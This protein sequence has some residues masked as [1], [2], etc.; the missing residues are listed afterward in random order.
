MI[1]IH[2]RPTVLMILKFLRNYLAIQVHI[3][4]ILPGSEDQ[5]EVLYKQLYYYMTEVLTTALS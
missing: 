3:R 2:F 5:Y 4:N 1:C